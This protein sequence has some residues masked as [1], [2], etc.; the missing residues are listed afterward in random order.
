VNRGSGTDR[1]AALPVIVVGGGVIG[2]CCAF[3]LSKD[4]VPVVLLEKDQVCSGCS[5]GNLGLLAA[6]HSVP[7]AQPGVLSQALRWMF[8]PDSPFAVRWRI[9]PVLFRWLWRFYR[10]SRA[11][12]LENAT[13]DLVKQVL[14]SMDVYKQY[15]HHEGF[16]FGLEE[17]GLLELFVTEKSFEEAKRSAEM[18]RKACLR[19]DVL[20]RAQVIAAEP[21]AARTVIGGLLYHDDCH[22]PPATFVRGLAELSKQAG[23]VIHE[24]SEVTKF[25]VS[26][27]TITAVETPGRTYDCSAVVLAAGSAS[28]I[29]ARSLGLELPVQPARGFTFTVPR[30]GSWPARPLMFAEAKVLIT[31]LGDQLRIGGTL[32]LTDISSPINVRRARSVAKRLHEYLDHPISVDGVEPWSG[33]RPCSCDGFPIIGWSGRY[34]NLLFATGHGMLGITLG[35]LTGQITS[36]LVRGVPA[37][38][39]LSRMSTHRFADSL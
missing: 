32:E 1:D 8:D 26:N 37:S 4:G 10:A 9:D 7:L 20:D 23:A 17:Q 15:E 27:G 18:L 39:D 36:E 33:S 14:A 34:K 31:L 5:F 24:G 30:G 11:G 29:L 22:L 3:S 19:I 25:R 28:A 35:P 13:G 12:G 6:S 38:M 2:T 21:A 16:H